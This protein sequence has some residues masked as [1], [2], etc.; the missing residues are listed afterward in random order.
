MVVWYIVSFLY[1]LFGVVYGPSSLRMDGPPLL[2]AAG[3]L[4]ASIGLM[5]RGRSLPVVL[6]LVGASALFIARLHDIA[7]GLALD[8]E[9]EAARRLLFGFGCLEAPLV[10][11]P[12]NALRLLGLLIPVGF[13]CYATQFLEKHLTMRWSERRTAPRFPF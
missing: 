8:F 6:L 4:A 13:L 7:L 12:M 11:T 9:W 10:A 2:I 1:P 5:R 3:V